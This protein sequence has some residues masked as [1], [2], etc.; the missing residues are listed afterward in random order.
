MVSNLR[1]LESR[2]AAAYAK[3]ALLENSRRLAR[4]RELRQRNECLSSSTSRTRP[5]SEPSSDPLAVSE[6][7]DSTV[8]LRFVPLPGNVMT[9]SSNVTSSNLAYNQ[10]PQRDLRSKSRRIIRST[11]SI[12][13]LTVSLSPLFAASLHISL[14]SFFMSGAISLP[15]RLRPSK[16]STLYMFLFINPNLSFAFLLASA[17]CATCNGFRLNS[18]ALAVKI[19]G[20]HIGEMVEFSIKKLYFKFQNINKKLS[21]QQNKIAESIIK[22]IKEQIQF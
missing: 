2:V 16:T 3:L 12:A 4:F 6:V 15:A 18:E 21:D 19:D 7:Q 13:I 17:A 11:F 14:N 10:V 5:A 9:T 1:V 20:L 22:E 8:S